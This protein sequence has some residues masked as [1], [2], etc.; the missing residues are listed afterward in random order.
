MSFWVY[1]AAGDMVFEHLSA[2]IE[3]DPAFIDF[4]SLWSILFD[5]TVE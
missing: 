1:T 4:D 2:E 5:D 3:L